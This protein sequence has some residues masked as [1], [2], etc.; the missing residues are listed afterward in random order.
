M[1]WWC[2]SY[3]VLQECCKAC[4]AADFGKLMLFCAGVQ[5]AHAM[6]QSQ[7]SSVSAMQPSLWKGS[8]K[9]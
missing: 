2:H 6:L 4:C 9:A 8:W 7:V 1:C 3:T 5:A